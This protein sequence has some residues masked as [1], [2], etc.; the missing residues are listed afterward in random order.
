[1]RGYIHAAEHCQERIRQLE[2]ELRQERQALELA[3]ANARLAWKL[4]G[5]VGARRATE[6][7][8]AGA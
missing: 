8:R 5:W 4:A 1:M 2:A 7:D 3:E 6:A